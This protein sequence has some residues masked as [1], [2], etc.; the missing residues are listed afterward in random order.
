M[1]QA[2]LTITQSEHASVVKIDGEIDA[3]NAR[4]LLDRITAAV[5]AAHALSVDLTD[6][7]YV[8]SHGTFLLYELSRRHNG[9][10]VIAP[11]TSFAAFLLKITPLPEVIIDPT[12]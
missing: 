2:G 5:P 4:Q 11:E 9:L 12:E 8:D 6:V 3:G 1:T 10:R 7:S